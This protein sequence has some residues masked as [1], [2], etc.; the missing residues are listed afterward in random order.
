MKTLGYNR[1]QC[2]QWI[3]VPALLPSMSLV[4]LATVAWSLSAVDVALVIGPGNPP[5]LAVLAWQWL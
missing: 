1:W 4:L 2:L 3:I 5:T